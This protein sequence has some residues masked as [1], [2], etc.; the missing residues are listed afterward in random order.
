M[1]GS[2]MVRPDTA[3]RLRA[4]QRAVLLAQQRI[5]LDHW[6]V[7]VHAAFARK[8]RRR[9]PGAEEAAGKKIRRPH[10]THNRAGRRCRRC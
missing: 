7:G 5:E 6:A 10:A 2:P 1:T 4:R 8:A 3:G 9:L